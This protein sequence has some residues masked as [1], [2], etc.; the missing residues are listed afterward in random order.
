MLEHICKM[1]MTHFG[2]LLDA[3]TPRVLQMTINSSESFN[4]MFKGIRAVLMSGIM[5]YSFRK[6]NEYFV[7]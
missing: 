2:V 3:V 7:N 6:C 5:E 4:K 1:L